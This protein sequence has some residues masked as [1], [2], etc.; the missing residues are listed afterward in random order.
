MNRRNALSIAV[1]FAFGLALSLSSAAAQQKQHV[2]FKSAAENSKYTEQH[3]IDVGDIPGHQVRVYEIHRTYPT[4]TPM[5]TCSLF[6]QL[7]LRRARER[8]SLPL[9]CLE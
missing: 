7:W 4:N 2:S 8:E 1:I 3:V 9:L 5:A 6:T